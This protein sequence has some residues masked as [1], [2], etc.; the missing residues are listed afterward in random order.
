MINKFRGE[1]WFL[2][3]FYP[4]SFSYLGKAW[5]T[6]EHFYMAAKTNDIV[7]K[8]QI[9]NLEKPGQAKRLGRSLQL[10][11]DWEDV[12]KDAML[13]A[14]RLKF[15]QNQDIKEK[16]IKT[17]G[18]ELIEGN[19]WHDNI[20]GN[21]SCEKCKDIVGENLLGKTLMI[22]RSELTRPLL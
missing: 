3:N 14:L 4:A 16:L 5:P 10:R 8:E 19:T 22:V 15:S 12:K 2:S 6:S 13:L 18:L 11:P 1:Y 9:R 21:C 7:I 17:G 20:W